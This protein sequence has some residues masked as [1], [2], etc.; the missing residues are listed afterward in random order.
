MA[1][2]AA[3]LAG[4]GFDP[5]IV[6]DDPNFHKRDSPPKPS[7]SGIYRS[8][9]AETVTDLGFNQDE[10]ISP[11]STQ[12]L[13]RQEREER[14]QQKDIE[15]DSGASK[16]HPVVV[17]RA[18]AEPARTTSDGEDTQSPVQI[19]KKEQKRRARAAAAESRRD[20]VADSTAP[21]QPSR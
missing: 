9:F 14:R 15:R 1:N 11:K 2:I 17:E 3:G 18:S 19:S 6:I 16:R 21:P 13:S 7:G 12:I 4:T 20:D 8:P 5:N 10:D